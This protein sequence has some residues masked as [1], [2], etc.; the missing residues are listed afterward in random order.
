MMKN[1]HTS[2][3]IEGVPSVPHTREHL[4]ILFSVPLRFFIVKKDSS[5]WFVSSQIFVC[6]PPGPHVPTC[7]QHPDMRTLF[8]FWF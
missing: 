2:E 1:K 8:F 3:N 5:K 7:P 6:P 4:S